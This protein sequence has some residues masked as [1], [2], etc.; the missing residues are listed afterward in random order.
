MLLGGEIQPNTG[1]ELPGEQ[2]M[3]L[4]LSRATFGQNYGIFL[5]GGRTF[6][7]QRAISSGCLIPLDQD[8]VIVG[9]FSAG[10]AARFA[11]RW[12]QQEK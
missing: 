2:T 1:V 4:L 11:T 5:L 9:G 12:W 6:D 10:V 3:M 7:L 8:F